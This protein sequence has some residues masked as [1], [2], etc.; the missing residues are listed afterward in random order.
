M[1]A[2]KCIAFDLDDTLVDTSQL[3]VPLAAR[4]ACEAMINNGVKGDIDTCLA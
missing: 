3:L 1:A 2:I 4:Q